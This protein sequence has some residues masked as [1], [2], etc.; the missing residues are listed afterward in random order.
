[1]LIRRSFG[2]TLQA[3]TDVLWKG[4]PDTSLEAFSGLEIQM[5]DGPREDLLEAEYKAFAD[6]IA[7]LTW[8]Q[9]LLHELGIRSSL[10]PILWCDNL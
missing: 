6:T 10:T 8:L 2:S 4:N 5:I 9:A 7:E 1:M 3:F